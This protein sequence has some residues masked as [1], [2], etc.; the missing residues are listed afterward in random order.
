MN[1]EWRTVVGY[2]MSDQ[3][4]VPVRLARHA[5]PDDRGRSSGAA[6]G[7]LRGAHGEPY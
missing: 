4:T 2:R 6:T 7:G 5:L 1:Q 3:K